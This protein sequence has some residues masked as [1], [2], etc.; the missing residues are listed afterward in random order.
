MIAH[1]ICCESPQ[2]AKAAEKKPSSTQEKSYIVSCYFNLFKQL[3]EGPHM[4]LE[5]VGEKSSD[6][7]AKGGKS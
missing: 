3:L 7:P 6:C 4:K 1:Q 5:E 2:V